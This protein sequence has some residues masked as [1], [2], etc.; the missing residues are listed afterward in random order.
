MRPALAAIVLAASYLGGVFLPG[1]WL[2]GATRERAGSSFSSPS[3]SRS[4]PTPPSIASRV[5]GYLGFVVLVLF[6]VLAGQ[7][8]TSGASLIGWPIL[9]L[10]GRRRRRGPPVATAP[11][12]SPGAGSSRASAAAPGD[13]RSRRGGAHRGSPC[14]G[15]G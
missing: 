6:V 10:I 4:R 7:P 5:P 12:P 3:A 9:L 14:R 1:G 13:E 2:A 11:R 15:A 8:S